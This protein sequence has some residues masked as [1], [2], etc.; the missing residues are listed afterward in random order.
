MYKLNYICS[1][2]I[3]YIKINNNKGKKIKKKLSL[4]EI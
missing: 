4:I 1:L 3:D 2:N